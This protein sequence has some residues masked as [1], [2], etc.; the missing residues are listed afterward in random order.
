[1]IAFC[2]VDRCEMSRLDRN[3]SKAVLIRRDRPMCKHAAVSWEE[4]LSI[5]LT[6]ADAE[7]ES[8]SVVAWSKRVEYGSS[9]LLARRG[10]GAAA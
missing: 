8:S 10:S 9:E 4:T 1:M 7:P 5:I 6:V 2:R 3:A